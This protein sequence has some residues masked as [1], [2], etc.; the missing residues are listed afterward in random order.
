MRSM[1]TTGSGPCSAAPTFSPTWA[2]V[3]KPG[4]GSVAG[5]R[6]QIQPS[7]PWTSERPSAVSS[8]RASAIRSR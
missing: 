7:A 2:T 1:R 3:R 6:P 4:R 5:L 8:A